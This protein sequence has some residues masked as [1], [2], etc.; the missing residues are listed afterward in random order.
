[1]LILLLV[2][3]AKSMLAQT[4][5]LEFTVDKTSR[6]VTMV[7]DENLAQQEINEKTVSK[8]IGIFLYGQAM[9]DTTTRKKGSGDGSDQISSAQPKTFSHR[10]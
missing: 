7:A 3:S 4:D 10:P 8:P 6:T 2:I 9:D 1:M 5:N